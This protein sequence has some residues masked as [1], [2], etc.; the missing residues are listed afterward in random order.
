MQANLPSQQIQPEQFWY[1]IDAHFKE[2]GLVKQQLS[3]YNNFIKKVRDVITSDTTKIEISNA[4]VLGISANDEEE[5]TIVLTDPIF[6]FPK[7]STGSKA[8]ASL[9]PHEARLRSLTYSCQLEVKAKDTIRKNGAEEITTVPKIDIASIPSMLKSDVCRLKRC[10]TQPSMINKD[11]CSFEQGGYFIIKG[12]EKVVIAQEKMAP[13][14]V[15]VFEGSDQ[16]K[17]PY[18]GNINS[19]ASNDEVRTHKIRMDYPKLDKSRL[20]IKVPVLSLSRMDCDVPVVLLF[21]ALGYENDQKIVEAICFDEND[22]EMYN[23]VTTAIQANECTTTEDARR[24]LGEHSKKTNKEGVIEIVSENIQKLQRDGTEK[25]K[26]DL[27]PH[28]GTDN[29]ESK[30]QF[31]GY[32]TNHFLSVYTGKR[33]GD[34][35]DHLARKRMLMTGGLMMELFKNSLKRMMKTARAQLQKQL[36]SNKALEYA[37]PLS[38]PT[39]TTD[40]TK[41][42]GTGNWPQPGGKES[43]HG[44]AQVLSRL[45]FTSALAYLRKISSPVEG[46]RKTQK[47][48]QLHNTQWGYIC[49]AETPE[50]ESCGLVKMLSLMAQITVALQD[51]QVDE[52]KEALDCQYVCNINDCTGEKMNNITKVFLNGVWLKCSEQPQKLLEELKNYRKNSTKGK[53]KK[54]MSMVLD[55]LHKEL[56]IYTDAGRCTRP[57]FTVSNNNGHYT[58]NLKQSQ[59][60]ELCSRL[61]NESNGTEKTKFWNNFLSKG[62]IEYVDADEEEMSMIAM[63]PSDLDNTEGGSSKNYTHC[64]IHP[65]LVMGVLGSIIPFP[66]HNQ[67]PRNTYQCAMGKQAIGVYASNYQLRL[68]SLGHVLFY[69]QKPLVSTRAA[70]Y[71]KF[72]HIP[73]GI[74]AIVAVCCYSGYNQEDSVMMNQ[75]SIDRGLFRSMAFKTFSED[76]KKSETTELMFFKPS[77]NNSEITEDISKYE[78]VDVDGILAPGTKVKPDDIL[79]AGFYE[80]KNKTLKDCSL[81]YK[82]REN[83]VV[84]QVVVTNAQSGTKYIRV[85]MRSIRIPQIGDKFSSR[86]GQKGTVG[87]TYRQEDMPFTIEGISPDIIMNPHA[88]PSR[89]TVGQLVE[90]L[91]GK[92]GALVGDVQSGTPFQKDVT[93]DR[94]GERLHKLKYQR[95]GYE[96]LFSGH[97]GRKLD[98]LVY[99]GPTYYQ[100][101]KH[102]VDDKVHGRATGPYATLTRQPLEGRSRDGGLRLGEME[103]DCMISHGVSSLLKERLFLASDKYQIYVCD[104]CHMP[105]VANHKAC[106]FQ[107]SCCKDKTH[108]SKV[109]IPYACKLLFQ[110]LMSMAVCPRIYTEV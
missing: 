88:I 105:A 101:L 102:L 45:T 99:I 17:Y 18:E 93:V 32:M 51:E 28:I 6:H 59:I 31:L 4:E 83:G 35:R 94:I 16:L 110:E 108:I 81:R 52:I 11:E 9:F 24:W 60:T 68:D 109:D 5:H 33:N 75:G 103:R 72:G 25:L 78:K 37:K 21:V 1:L 53:V 104:K 34:D 36:S 40:F 89:M 92:V 80:N 84:D 38:F 61:D 79:V 48:R 58:L 14:T 42:L 15:L 44:V 12:S 50:G 100:R 39:I 10:V 2:N 97:T 57:L 87:M 3:S 66:D 49:P 85:K 86:H 77:E 69:P 23:I 46:K 107:C 82:P 90:C 96:A 22:N 62:I 76:A 41:A 54:V 55:Q 106:T 27:L 20:K 64:E 71:V 63:F 91:L 74:N 19:L 26:K 67:S 7:V 30:A 47:P 43:R 56:R 13:N 65:A 95:R 73:A 8:S 29:F 98:S 70:E